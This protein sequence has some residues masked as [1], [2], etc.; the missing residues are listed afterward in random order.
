MQ[1]RRAVAESVEYAGQPLRRARVVGQQ[2]QGPGDQP[3]GVFGMVGRPRHAHGHPP[4]PELTATR[5][6]VLQA[7]V[8]VSGRPGGAAALGVPAARAPE[9]ERN[10]RLRQEPTLPAG[11]VY[12]GVLYAALGLAALDPA[13]ARRAARRLLVVSALFGALRVT[14]RIPA[15]RLAMG[16]SLEPL[17][18]PARRE[19]RRRRG[20]R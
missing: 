12:T 18:R 15:Y 4:L 1:H 13:A 17:G 3:P 10:T 20:G 7:L 9:V 14:D 8:T 16:V 6:A 2:A 19:R 5:A 11:S